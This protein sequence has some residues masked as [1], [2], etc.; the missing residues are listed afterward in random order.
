MSELAQS[1]R[2]SG[3]HKWPDLADRRGV[4]RSDPLVPFGDAQLAIPRYGLKAGL[5]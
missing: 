2:F 5:L 1:G 3:D 4:R